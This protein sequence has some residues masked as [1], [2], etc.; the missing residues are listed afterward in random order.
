MYYTSF[1][2]RTGAP[3]PLPRGFPDYFHASQASMEEKANIREGLT[4]MMRTVMQGLSED[5]IKS[6][7]VTLHMDEGY[8]PRPLPR[9]ILFWEL[10]TTPVGEAATPPTLYQRVRNLFTRSAPGDQ[11]RPGKTQG[12]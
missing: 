6:T 2:D 10:E 11:Q 5:E 12:K 1:Y 8:Q 7:L 4:G 3:D 9:E